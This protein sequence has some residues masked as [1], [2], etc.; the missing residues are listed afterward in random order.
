MKYSVVNPIARPAQSPIV[1][2]KNR[3]LPLSSLPFTNAEL[4]IYPCQNVH[5]AR[6]DTLFLFIP[7]LDSLHL[8]KVEHGELVGE[9]CEGDDEDAD[10]HQH[11]GDEQLQLQRRRDAV[12][13]L[14]PVEVSGEE[15]GD[16]ADN[17]AGRAYQQ[18]VRHRREVVVSAERR[19]G[20]DEQRRAGGLGVGAEQVGAHPGNVADVVTHIVSDH[21]H[22]HK[23]SKPSQ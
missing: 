2:Q 14:D 23:M 13:G 10:G 5:G 20:R 16:Q 8:S 17:E 18:R 1:T 11:G 21:L 7:V 4:S 3:C 15:R 12:D 22:Q 19:D 6:G 9:G